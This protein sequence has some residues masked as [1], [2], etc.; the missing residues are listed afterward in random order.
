MATIEL[1]D[2]NPAEFNNNLIVYGRLGVGTGSPSNALHIYGDGAN[3]EIKAER[4]SGAVSLIQAQASLVRFGATSNHNLHLI[5]NDDTKVTITTGGRLGIG[6][7]SP[8]EKLHVNSG[9]TNTVALFESTDAGAGIKL[10][11]TTGSSIVQTNVTDLRIGVDEDGAVASSTMSFR[12]DGSTKMRIDSSGNCGLGLISPSFASGGG[13]HIKNASRANLKIETGSSACEQFV[14]GNDFYLDH[15][16]TG[17]IVFRN[18]TRTERMRI[19]SDGALTSTSTSADAVF[20]KSSHANNTNVYIN[21]TNATTGNTANLYF[22]PANDVNGAKISAIATEDFSTSANRSADLALSTRNNGNWVEAMRLSSGNVGI[23]TTTPTAALTVGDGTGSESIEINKS[24]SGSATLSFLNAGSAKVYFQADANEHLRIATNN[25][26]RMS[27]LEDGNVGI[28]ETTPTEKLHVNGNLKVTGSV[29]IGSGSQAT[30]ISEPGPF[31]AYTLYHWE[32]K[33]FRTG[34]NSYYD[35]P[36]CYADADSPW[37]KSSVATASPISLMS[38]HGGATINTGSHGKR[39]YNWDYMI[40]FNGLDVY[41]AFASTT[42]SNYVAI[43][44]PCYYT[45]GSSDHHVFHLRLRYDKRCGVMLWV[46]DSSKVPQKKAHG[47]FNSK[48]EGNGRGAL[49]G[50]RNT[51]SSFNYHAHDWVPFT[52]RGDYI[53]TYSF[54]DSDSPTGRSIYFAVTNAVTSESNGTNGQWIAGMSISRNKKGCMITAPG[55]LYHAVNGSQGR[56]GNGLTHHGPWH[57]SDFFYARH[58]RVGNCPVPIIGTDKD[59]IMT[60]ISTGHPDHWGEG[61]DIYLIDGSGNT[62]YAGA[63]G[64]NGWDSYVPNQVYRPGLSPIGSFQSL[65]HRAGL[66]HF[67]MIPFTII[68]PQTEVARCAYDTQ[69]ILSLQ[70]GF[71]KMHDPWRDGNYRAIATEPAI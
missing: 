19:A 16:P 25:S 50:P 54:A 71:S 62:R 64:N 8:S 10:T 59:I 4:S 26:V 38:T 52:I 48:R 5:S 28:N 1:R 22:G 18:D 14:D 68:I 13:L 40:A 35:T 21:N 58:D 42:P 37:N 57:K 43:K 30:S 27:I 63:N 70:I 7:T 31:D 53:D 33:L 66:G 51:V 9:A 67:G 20:L 32:S 46:C 49:V 69:G 15:Y 34:V 39:N 55:A 36:L 61:T 56:G 17:S 24:T 65:G 44:M 3:G 45:S 41:N 47:N 29:K 23:G 12:V 11:D 2:L 6:T 60:F